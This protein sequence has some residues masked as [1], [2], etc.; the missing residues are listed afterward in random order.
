MLNGVDSTAPELDVDRRYAWDRSA[1]PRVGDP[2]TSDVIDLDLPGVASE[3][4]IV[5]DA[6][7]CVG[8]HAAIS[9]Y[10]RPGLIET[11]PQVSMQCV[12]DHLGDL[13]PTSRRPFFVSS[14][15]VL[16]PHGPKRCFD[17]VRNRLPKVLLSGSS[18][19]TSSR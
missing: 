14:R 12:C 7:T 1:R 5:M 11:G 19:M 18:S 6:K 16:T 3:D 13:L 17:I 15:T 2:D 10:P 8:G 9:N 4:A